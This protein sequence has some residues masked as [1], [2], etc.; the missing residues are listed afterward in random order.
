[1][2]NLRGASL[3]TLAMLGFAI[4]DTFIKL[5]ADSLQVSQII[6]SMGA[7]GAII[8]GALTLMQGRAL[9]EPDL[10][11]RAVLLRNL[12]ELLG[13][14]GF[15]TALAMSTL[16]SASAILQ[17]SP[18]MVTLGAALFLKERVGWRRWS[19]IFAGFFGVLLV[20]RPGVEG[21]DPGALFALLGVAGLVLRDLATRQVPRHTS[22]LQLSFLGFATLIPT[23]GLLRLL[24]AGV[25]MW[26][27]PIQWVTIA[28]MVVTLAAA[29]FCI[30]SAMRV[31]E[32]SYVTPFR[33]TRIVFAL[34]AGYFV[35]DERPDALMLVGAA[36]IVGAGIYTVWRER[37]VR[38]IA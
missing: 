22:S 21:I 10:L 27:T 28:A 30:V 7:G 38:P 13:T 5:M 6:A 29:Y 18:L 8:F 35:F 36:I 25:W 11:T 23:A 3:M 31:G 12:G 15:V 17:V 33:Y 16:S 26:P 32:V 34:V 14:L 37:R 20:V 1:M 24:E 2:E 4:A 19:A 9:V